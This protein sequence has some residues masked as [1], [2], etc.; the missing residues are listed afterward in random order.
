MKRLL[1]LAVI[2]TLAAIGLYAVDKSPSQPKKPVVKIGVILPLTGNNDH[3]GQPIRALLQYKVAH[4]PK[5]SRFNYEL[6]FEDDQATPKMSLLAA[7]R[8]AEWTG[9]DV[10][11]TYLASPAGVVAPYATQRK[12]PHLMWNFNT[13]AADGVFNFDHVAPIGKCVKL[14]TQQADKS[15]QKK[16][17]FLVLR[18]VGGEVMMKAMEAEKAD[19]KLEWTT[20]ERFNP[21]ERDFRITLAKMRETNPQRL[22]IFGIEPE[23]QIILRQMHE[24][25]WKLPVTTISIFDLA[26]DN[27]SLEGAWYVGV[28]APTPAYRAWYMKTFKKPTTY[29]LPV[30]DDY[31]EMIYRACEAHK[32]ANKPT[33]EELAGY[34]KSVKDF[35]GACGV[36][37]CN[38]AGVFET[39]PTLLTIKNGVPVPLEKTEP[40]KK[41]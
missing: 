27:P 10:L 23:L 1:I 18:S 5:D 7:H 37:S 34:L 30:Y 29:G 3:L 12:I 38:D 15:D 28:D 2:L 20:V 4:L 24:I 32:G 14:W 21:G 19:S 31:L 9:V 39:P 41:Q 17:G 16:I 25:G 6:Y 40:Q 11:M 8:L 33:G 22:F 26:F 36:I 13:K 35:D